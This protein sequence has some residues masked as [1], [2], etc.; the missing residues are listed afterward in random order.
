MLQIKYRFRAILRARAVVV[1]GK[2]TVSRNP[3]LQQFT[4]N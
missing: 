1:V 2:I 4:H 3:G